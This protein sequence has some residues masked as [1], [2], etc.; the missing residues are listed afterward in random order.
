MELERSSREGEYPTDAMRCNV[1][2]YVRETVRKDRKDEGK[3]KE[4]YFLNLLKY[5]LE[6]VINLD[7]DYLF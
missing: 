4:M 3:K 6:K 2:V 5:E 7:V 1:Y